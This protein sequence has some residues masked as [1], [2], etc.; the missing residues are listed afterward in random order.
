[1]GKWFANLK[2]NFKAKLVCF[3][4]RSVLLKCSVW[5]SIC[6]MSLRNY[7][8][9]LGEAYIDAQS[10]HQCKCV[11]GKLTFSHKVNKP[12]NSVEC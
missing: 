9:V 10:V 1:M 5:Q 7:W 6:V 11:E 8:N 2:Q 12:Q 4:N 3:S